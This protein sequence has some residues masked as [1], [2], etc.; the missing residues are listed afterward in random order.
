MRDFQEPGRS[1]VYGLNGAVATSHPLASAAALAMLTRGGHAIDAAI[2]ASAVLCVVEPGMTGIG[3]DNFTIIAE[4]DGTVRA[5]NGSGRSPAGTDPDALRAG[6]SE[7]ALKA[8]RMMPR[9]SSHS[10]TVPGAVDA[11]C[12]LHAQYG[13]LDLAEVLAPAVAYAREGYVVHA[14]VAHDWPN[15]VAKLARDP[16]AAAVML[17]GGATPVEGAVHRQPALAA[18]LEAVGQ[19]GRAAFYEGAAAEDMVSKLRA[20]GG[21]HSLEDFAAA[22]GEW[23]APIRTSYRGHELLECPPNGQGI[24]P[25]IMLNIIDR[26]EID[27]FDPLGVERIHL[28]VEAAKLA[29]EDRDTLIA[30]PRAGA[31]PVDDLLSSDHAR[32][33]SRLIDPGRA[34]ATPPASMPASED[35]IYLCVVDRDGTAVSFINS[36]FENFGS[37]ILAP[38]SGV[39]FH[40][41][42]FSFRLDPRHPNTIAPGKRP[43]HTIIPAMLMRGG[44]PVMPFGVM[45]AHFQ[46]FGQV[47][48]LTNI[49][50][51]G[52]DIQEAQ[53]LARPFGYAGELTLER[54]ISESVACGLADLGHTVSRAASPH[55]GS[56]GIRIDKA[57]GVLSAGS[58]PR[59]DGCALAW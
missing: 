5:Y 14:R 48:M 22:E 8:G 41:R 33:R 50:N 35:T 54:G 58:D 28:F 42:G 19:S 23:I 34:M 21:S 55:G 37:G 36:I 57:T 29:Y 12:R 59:K 16:D 10:V 20:L 7:R 49:L 1:P 11:W 4:S 56:Q 39:M 2:A 18:T 40:N 24:V 44:A 46:P 9:Y 51:Y 27:V 25:L 30:D 38:R 53:D 15:Q 47:W 17:P 3:G 13:R 52:M 31:V 32:A 45:G 43:L 26:F 6:I